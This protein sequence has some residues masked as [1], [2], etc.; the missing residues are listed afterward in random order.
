MPGQQGAIPEDIMSRSALPPS[1]WKD[2]AMNQLDVA[3]T[4]AC[5]SGCGGLAGCREE[6][7]LDCKGSE[8]LSFVHQVQ[9]EQGNGRNAKQLR[10]QIASHS[11]TL[12]RRQGAGMSRAS[13]DSK[14]RSTG[15]DMGQQRG[16]LPYNRPTD[17]QLASQ[18]A[19]QEALAASLSTAVSAGDEN[20]VEIFKTMQGQLLRM[21]T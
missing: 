6:Y 15:Y 14:Q 7:S 8:S 3:A 10:Q 21:Q 11:S 2:T 1:Q 19:V 17:A 16:V 13:R 9:L 12:M 18:H 5:V 20:M 4:A